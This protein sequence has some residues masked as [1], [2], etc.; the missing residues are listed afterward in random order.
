M[1]TSDAIVMV[2]TPT[3]KGADEAAQTL[4]HL[5]RVAPALSKRYLPICIGGAPPL[6]QAADEPQW[7][8][9]PRDPAFTSDRP[10][11]WDD[12]ARPTRCALTHTGRSLADLIDKEPAS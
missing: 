9:I 2:H 10:M 7:Q 1:Q 3:R 5:R 11:R 12:L 4:D 8:T 6:P